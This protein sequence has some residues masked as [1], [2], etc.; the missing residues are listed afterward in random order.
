MDTPSQHFDIFEDV[1]SLIDVAG[2]LE[3]TKPENG[4]YPGSRT[5]DLRSTNPELFKKLA[6][7]IASKIVG[8]KPENILYYGNMYFQK[9]TKSDVGFE[10]KSQGW[11]HKDQNAIT[12]VVYLTK[13]N[14]NAGT[15]IYKQVGQFER[16]DKFR[17]VKHQFF[18]SGTMTDEYIKALES[19]HKGFERIN[20][21][22][23]VYNSV[24]SF[25][26]MDWHCAD[27][28]FTNTDERLTLIVFFSRIED[29]TD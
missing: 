27:F 11:M 26:P 24:V 8:T 3:F 21:Y 17:K 14:E 10:G 28:D 20:T 2:T 1:E 23:S 13:D 22:K 18:A 7:T 12:S 29:L 19:N 16:G 25:N 4:L 9:I 15:S 5:K 6:G